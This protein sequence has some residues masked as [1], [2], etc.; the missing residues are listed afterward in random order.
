MQYL[1]N[2]GIQLKTPNRK[3]HTYI[4]KAEVVGSD[5]RVAVN[6]SVGADVPMN[7]GLRM[8]VEQEI[9]EIWKLDLSEN[10]P[11]LLE[12]SQDFFTGVSTHAEVP[13]IPLTWP[14]GIQMGGAH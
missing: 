4:Y 11:V 13:D 5:V 3:W 12:R 14:A 7:G 2:L 1:S 6:S 10:S 8:G 9:Y